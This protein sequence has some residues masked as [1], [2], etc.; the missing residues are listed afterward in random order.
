MSSGRWVGEGGGQRAE[1][2]CVY[3]CV[4]GEVKEW[5]GGISVCVGGEGGGRRECDRGELPLGKVAACL[6]L[7]PAPPAL[8]LCLPCCP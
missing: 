4:G 8:K 1:G 7:N 3:V 2:S 6:P 5:K